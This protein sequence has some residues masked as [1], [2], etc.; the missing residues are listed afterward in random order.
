MLCTFLTH[1]DIDLNFKD[2]EFGS[3]KVQKSTCK[4]GRYGL[5]FLQDTVPLFQNNGKT[6][7]FLLRSS[8]AQKA[9]DN[10]GIH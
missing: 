8:R 9:P 1:L 6:W 4:E 2:I 7:L 3:F 5:M 10:I